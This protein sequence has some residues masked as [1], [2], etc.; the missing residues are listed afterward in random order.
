M[1]Q[2]T[3]QQLF[4]IKNTAGD[5]VGPVRIIDLEPVLPIT[6]VDSFFLG[7]GCY[8][9]DY[10]LFIQRLKGKDLSNM[11]MSSKQ[12]VPYILCLIKE[13]NEKRI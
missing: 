10:R 8:P 4:R 6:R 1:L 7:S 2:Q 5:I 12:N 9:A 11:C 13:R 3:T